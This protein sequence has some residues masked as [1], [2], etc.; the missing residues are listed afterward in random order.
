MKKL[1]PLLAIAFISFMG[2]AQI[3]NIPDAN[4]KAKLL[5]AS[6]TNP[7]A[8]TET[9]SATGAVSSYTKID[10]NNDSQIQVSEALAI[11]YLSVNSNSISD[12]TG[13]ESFT[14]LRTLS[15]RNNSLTALNISTLTN[16]E[17]L[18]CYDNQLISLDTSNSPN[19]K[20]LN[21]YDNSLTNLNIN[22][23]MLLTSLECYSNQLTTLDLSNRTY[24]TNLN[25]AENLLTTL[26]I[27]NNLALNTLSFQH[28]QIQNINLDS[29][30]NIQIMG[31]GNNPYTAPVNLSTL[32]NL[33]WL[34]AQNISDISVFP[35]NNS[36]MPLL[37]NLEILKTDGSNIGNF[38]YG[39]IPNLKQL[40]CR[41]SGMTSMDNI[42]NGLQTLAVE[43]NQITTLDFTGFTNL[44]SLNFSRNPIT[45]LTFGNHPNLGTVYASQT[46][47]TDIDVSMLPALTFLSVVNTSSLISVNIKNGI[48]GNLNFQ[49]CPNLIYICTDENEITTI[50]DAIVTNAANWN[51]NPNCHV[52]SYCS[53]T[54][55]GTFY[56]IQGNN[57]YDSDN[58]G[59]NIS[60]IN[61]PN[62]KLNFSD[63]T[64][65][66]ILIPD[67]SGSYHYDVQA[68]T[69]TFIPVLDNPA[70]F[71][72]SPSTATASFPDIASP[73]TQNFCVTANGTH[74]DLEVTL[75]PIG[76][77]RPGFDAQYKIIYKNKGTHSQSGTINFT[78]DDNILQLVSA[79]PNV[80]SQGTDSL[81]WS[82]TNL[83]PFETREI[84]VVLNLNSPLETPPVN[85]DNWIIFLATISGAIDET[86][87]DNSSALTQIVV[88][89]FDPN[90]K[91]CS[92]GTL[93]P[94][95]LVGKYVNYVIRFENTGT[96]AAEN[97]VV[98]DIIDTTKFDITTLSP[99]AGSHSFTTRISNTN[100]VEFIFENINL[101]FD[102]ANND[103]YVAFKI[104][105]KPN[106]VEGDI[107][108]NSADIYFD[109]NAPIV[110]DSYATTIYQ[111]LNTSDYNF[112]DIFSLSPV[113]AKDWLT[114]TT[115]ETVSMTSISIYNTLG[116]LIQVNTNPVESIDVSG[117]QSGS[118]FI[119]IV[120][121]KG[122]TTGKFIKE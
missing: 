59:C 75:F 90:D 13:I 46:T 47:L 96:S 62:L 106:L 6:S 92:V 111:P 105:T 5:S 81:T 65:S 69:H 76:P 113:P 50:Q 9:P 118:Y 31:M 39:L 54:P 63:G 29:C 15:C 51:G 12:L 7:I 25:C 120:S 38:N 102:N 89:S 108:S 58:N 2:N 71:N 98:K 18:F 114:I 84:Q 49:N 21:C 27:T 97:I 83:L 20:I 73:F 101:P 1:Y 68:G 26:N 77:A 36:S 60:N 110:T 116:Q 67:A 53:F 4:F 99:L 86:Q 24:L 55:G 112:S 16:L 115:H 22:N 109:Y 35:L 41:S 82:F 33:Y 66:A 10:T 11:K 78:Y 14:N 57:K 44:I 56:T 74:N 93:M 100:Q 95:Q 85:A 37:T 45:S 19:L 70:Y 61:I 104:K 88:N 17:F 52:N 94:V 107:F 80:S 119:K 43:N 42:P 87:D 30:V 34:D 3:V 40:L 8:S 28:N 117:L 64:N 72:V 122:A 48:S 79:N 23:C 121:D 91:T 32:V 103:G